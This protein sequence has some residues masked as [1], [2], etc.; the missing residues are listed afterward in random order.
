M[1]GI[2]QDSDRYGGI[3]RSTGRPKGSTVQRM[4]GVINGDFRTYGIVTVVASMSMCMA[5]S[6]VAA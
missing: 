5:W 1:A 2:I 3:T 6:P 4:E